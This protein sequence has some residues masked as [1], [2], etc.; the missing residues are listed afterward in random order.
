MVSRWQSDRRRDEQYVQRDCDRQLHRHRHHERLRERRIVLD[1]RDGQSDS[2]DPDDHAGRSDDLLRRRQR[3]ADVV[4]RNRQSVVPRRQSDRRRDEQHLQR[5]S[6]GQLHRRRHHERLR[7]RAVFGNE[8]H[9]QFDTVN[10][11]D[12]AERSDDLLHRRQRHA[13]VE[14]R[15]GQSVVPQR[16]SD[17]RRDRT[18]VR[19]DRDR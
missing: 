13:D 4:E 12:H 1:E 15:V 7:E 17:Q 10:A 16:Q 8:R 19:R 6:V 3:S 14:Q 9:R 11:D 5:G 2:G 18:A